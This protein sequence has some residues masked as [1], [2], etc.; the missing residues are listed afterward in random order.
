[1]SKVT[2]TEHAVLMC[3]LSEYQDKL[4]KE[5]DKATLEYFNAKAILNAK[6]TRMRELA[7]LLDAMAI[8]LKHIGGAA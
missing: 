3:Q 8:T 1:M 5:V 7:G 2:I 4:Q 6:L